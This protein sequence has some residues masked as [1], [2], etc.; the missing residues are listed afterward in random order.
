MS[1][2]RLDLEQLPATPWKNGGGSTR[3]LA[4]FPE[5]AGLDDFAW[6]ISCARVERDGAFST[7]PGVDRSL[8]LLHGDG[9]RLRRGDKAV[10]LQPCAPPLSFAGE[11]AISAELLGAGIDDLNLMTRRGVWRQQLQHLHLNGELRLPNDAP[12]LLLWCTG[13]ELECELESGR[14]EQ[15]GPNQGLLLEN[16]KQLLRI[17]GTEQSCCYV[18]RLYPV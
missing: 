12:V 3:Q 5:A 6:R 16:E 18:G 10:L 4:I 9:L 11:E 8:A 14:T 1:L 13:G 15:L 2:R 17:R 7:Y